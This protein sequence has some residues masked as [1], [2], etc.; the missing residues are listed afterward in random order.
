MNRVFKPVMIAITAVLGIWFAGTA[1]VAQ[2]N[3]PR[4][5]DGKPNLNGIW[6]V[7]NTAAWDIQDHTGALGVPPGQGVVE[8]NVIPYQTQ[9]LAKKRENAAKGAE[10]L[11]PYILEAV[12]A[13]ATVGE[14]S[15]AFRRVHGQYQEALTI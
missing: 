15:N 7:L 12:E 6:Q 8:G 3:L 13:Y 14:I 11:M 2:S 4:T 9:A 10:N 5:A 1:S